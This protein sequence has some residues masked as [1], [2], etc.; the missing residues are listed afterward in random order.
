MVVGR[1]Q[2]PRTLSKDWGGVSERCQATYVAVIDRG[3]GKAWRPGRPWRPGE[4]R[5]AL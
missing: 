1:W 2:Q 3:A 5:W 4:A